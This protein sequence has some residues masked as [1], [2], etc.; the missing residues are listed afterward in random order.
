M[1]NDVPAREKK[2]GSHQALHEHAKGGGRSQGTLEERA[3]VRKE[4]KH[5]EE[6]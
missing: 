1:S 6:R 3:E 4:G 5:Q 2:C